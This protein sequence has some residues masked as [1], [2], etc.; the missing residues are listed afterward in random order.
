MNK[1]HQKSHWH[2][3]VNPMYRKARLLPSPEW[4]HI[5]TDSQQERRND[6]Q[7][8]V[9][10]IFSHHCV[11]C[12]NCKS[13]WVYFNYCLRHSNFIFPLSL[14]WIICIFF[15]LLFNL[16]LLWLNMC[17]YI[18]VEARGQPATVSAFLSPFHMWV[19]VIDLRSS[20]LVCQTP[21]PTETSL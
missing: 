10:S 16:I 13:T 18:H 14:P 9:M 1:S 20:G 6:R 12:N 15:L 5:T 11:S 7:G 4:Q 19:T 21:L 8:L 3:V 2:Q 17:T